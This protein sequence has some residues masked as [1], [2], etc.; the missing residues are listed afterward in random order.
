M[1]L[2]AFDGLI[3]R[4]GTGSLKWGRYGEG[5][6]PLWV[7]DMDFAS[8]PEVIEALERRV[9]HGVYGYTVASEE[10]EQAVVD[11]LASRHGVA[12]SRDWLSWL[13]GLVPGLN[14]ACRAYAG[15][16]EGVMTATP[17]YPPFLSAPRQ[18][19]RV[20]QGVPLVRDGGDWALDFAAMERAVRPET[21]VFLLCNPHNPVGRVYR[22]EELEDLLAFCERHELVL[23][24]DEIH[25]D[26]VL[27]AG[28]VHT[29]VLRLG[30]RAAARSVTLLSAAKTY[31][32][33]GLACGYALIPDPRLRAA[34]Q[35][36]GRG[37]VGEVSAFGYTA[38][39]AA[40][41]HGEGWRRELIAYLRGNRDALYGF[42]A[43]RLPGVQLWP[44]AATYLAWMAAA[45]LDLPDPAA[46]F[47]AHGV[48]L[49]D[50]ADFGAPGFLRLNFGCP[51]ARLMEALERM[52]A[53]VA[54]R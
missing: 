45:D 44:M 28:L 50:G 18:A 6:I 49:S 48:G 20:L 27:E 41:R 35:S 42:A 16:G 43:D 51:R 21:R 17:V 38:C 47:A 10:V 33:P 5:V 26:L 12:A 1:N 13:P 22:A 46:F 31:N 39:A 23:V 19:G 36:A 30:E 15:G 52:E 37:L 29:P 53:A 8:P 54:G 2:G 7:A 40:Y 34:F 24:S 11:Y 14:L 4:R 3:D 9:R 25:C 32:L